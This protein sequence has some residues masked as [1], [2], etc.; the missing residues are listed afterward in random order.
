MDQI[1][2][3]ILLLL[4]LFPSLIVATNFTQCLEDLRNDPDAVG[5]VD[6]WGN[7]TSP[8]AA[9]G[10]TYKTCTERCGSSPVPPNWWDFSQQFP[11]WLLPWLALVSQLPFNSGN[12]LD[13]FASSESSSSHFFTSPIACLNVFRASSVVMSVG[14]PAL[15]AYSLI[16]TALNARSVNRR[17]NRI[18][19]K[20][21]TDVARALV[22]LQQMSLELTKDPVFLASIPIDNRWEQEIVSRLNRK[23]AW[24]LAAAASAA[25]VVISFLITLI[26]SFISLNDPSVSIGGVAA[27]FAIGTLWLWLLCLV[28]GW[29]W[30]P[31]FTCGELKSA[32]EYANQKAA[33]KTAKRIR[34]ASQGGSQSINHANAKATD[35]LLEGTEVLRGPWEHTIEVVD[36]EGDEM[37][38]GGSVQ[39]GYRYGEQKADQKTDSL[40]NA[41]TG[42]FQLTSRGQRNRGH[43]DGSESRTPASETRSVGGVQ[44][45]TDPAVGELFISKSSSSL[46]WDES[47]C[48]VTFNYARVIGYLALVEDVSRMFDKHFQD[49][50]AVSILRKRQ[51]VSIVLVILNRRGDKSLEF[52]SSHPPRTV[53]FRPKRAVRSLQEHSSRCLARRFSALFYN[54][55]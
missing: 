51:T 44:N 30:V 15:A 28:I 18:E 23:N 10:F 6:S 14:S 48:A 49:K 20:N 40:L 29:M 27:G 32:L 46:N 43:L 42:S 26:N 3:R 4:L 52:L 2:A 54:A 5:G 55:G 50:D 11:S 7:P 12:Y 19:Y 41:S 16:L 45:W 38:E 33:K 34:Q 8:A 17:V 35:E 13:D 25:W 9:V 37:V 1:S 36:V 22:S 53:C 39:E 21:K 24:S 47:R 31:T